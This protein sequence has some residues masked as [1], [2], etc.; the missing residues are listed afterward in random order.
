M[1]WLLELTMILSGFLGHYAELII[2][3]I[4]LTI[5]AFIGSIN[6]RKSLKAIKFLEQKLSI[7]TKIL[8]NQKWVTRDIREIVPGDI[9][10]IGLGDIVPAD[11]KLLNDTIITVDQSALTG[12]SLPVD[13]NMSGIAYSGSII[14]YG[15]AQGVILNTGINTFFGKTI[16][17]VKTARPKSHQEQIMLSVIK[18]MLFISLAALFISYHLCT[19]YYIQIF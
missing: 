4:L 8:R 9:I 7:K 19:L 1:P 3:F 5:N 2:I 15:E 6:N 11:V 10:S 16:E 14:K 18:Y 12:E 17:L 13:V